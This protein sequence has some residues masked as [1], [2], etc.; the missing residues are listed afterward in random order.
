METE[1]WKSVDW[2]SALSANFSIVLQKKLQNVALDSYKN[3][4]IK[5]KV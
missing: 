3:E 2:L 4:R 5:W 1:Y